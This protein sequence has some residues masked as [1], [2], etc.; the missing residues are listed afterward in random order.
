MRRN[1][2]GQARAKQIEDFINDYCTNYGTA[3]SVREIAEGVGL[4]KT[5]VQ[6][7]LKQ[8]KETGRIEGRGHRGVY[9][10]RQLADR[11]SSIAPILGNIACGT[12]LLAEENIEEYVRLPEALFG[13]GNFFFLRAHGQSMTGAGIDDCDL[14]LVRMQ[15]T[16]DRGD[17]VVALIDNA[18][19]TLKR[20]FP[21]PEKGRIWLHPENPKEKEIYVEHD[22]EFQIQ[23]VA[24]KVVKNL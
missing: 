8:M 14:V 3:P 18:E 21:E 7:H 5:T 17:I 22:Q 15:E 23:G 4:G 19:T 24:V 6:Y 13:R 12:P 16:A 1:E 2:I 9:T 20:Y 10:E 11:K